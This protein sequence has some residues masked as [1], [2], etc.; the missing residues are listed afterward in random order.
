MYNPGQAERGADRGPTN[1]RGRIGDTDATVDG[2]TAMTAGNHVCFT[3]NGRTAMTAGSR[4]AVTV[5]L[6]SGSTANK[7]GIH[8]TPPFAG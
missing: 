4:V 8:A 1:G 6:R 5:T 3:R 7:A 2:C